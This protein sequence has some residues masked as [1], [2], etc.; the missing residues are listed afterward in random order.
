MGQAKQRGTF[1]ERLAIAV[2]RES[3]LAY[4]RTMLGPNMV[5]HIKKQVGPNNFS[6]AAVLL[7]ITAKRA[8]LKKNSTK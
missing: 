1:E 7:S 6:V 8:V 5:K 3:Q 4:G 2:E